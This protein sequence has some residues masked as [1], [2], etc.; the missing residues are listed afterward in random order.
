LTTVSIFNI[1]FQLSLT[2]PKPLV[3]CAEI[4]FIGMLFILGISLTIDAQSAVQ[5][6]GTELLGRPTDSS[7]T[8]NVIAD[9][10]IQAYIEYGTESGAYSGATE[11]VSQPADSPIEITLSGLSADTKYYYRFVYSSDEGVNWHERDEHTFHTQR[12]AGST[13]TFTITA[14]SHLG[15]YGGFTFRERNLYK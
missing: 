2:P 15:Q 1:K 3:N 14:D 12:P 6:T 13:F 4:L 9:A 8:L 7:I 11:T 5:F 10:S